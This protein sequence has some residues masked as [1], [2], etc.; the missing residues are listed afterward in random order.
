MR[1][2]KLH[3]STDS[4]PPTPIYINPEYIEAVWTGSENYNGTFISMASR[5][6]HLVKESVD[7]VYKLI[8]FDRA[9]PLP[10]PANTNTVFLHNL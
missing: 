6:S 7:E 5:D 10:D 1:L 3:K 2:I 4:M 8:F 9:I